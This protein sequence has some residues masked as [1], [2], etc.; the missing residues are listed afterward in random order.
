MQVCIF[1]YRTYTNEKIFVFHNPPWNTCSVTCVSTSYKIKKLPTRYTSS[2]SWGIGISLRTKFQNYAINL[3][4]DVYTH[5]ADTAINVLQINIYNV[6]ELS[7]HCS[8]QTYLVLYMAQQLVVYPTNPRINYWSIFFINAY[9]ARFQFVKTN[10]LVT[11]AVAS[12]A[13]GQL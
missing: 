3:A 13:T 12:Y 9:Y 10:D 1:P 4:M 8:L 2:L 5:T 11:S 7:H 6:T